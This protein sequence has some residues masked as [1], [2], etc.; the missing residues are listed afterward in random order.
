MNAQ[1]RIK[2]FLKMWDAKPLYG[3]ADS[4]YG[5]HVGTE[6]EAE[7][8]ITDLREAVTLNA[9]LLTALDLGKQAADKLAELFPESADVQMALNAINYVL[10][11]ARQ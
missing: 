8:T 9:E 1:E 5:F 6:W 4:I 11:K 3:R 7:L 10:H 2:H